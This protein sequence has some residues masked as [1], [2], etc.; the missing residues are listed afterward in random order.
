MRKFVVAI[1]GVFIFG[2]TSMAQRPDLPGH[3]IFDLG[4]NSWSKTPVGAD[5]NL[6]KSKDLNITYL[7]DLPLGDGGFTFTPGVGISLEKFAFDNNTT[8]TST[9]TNSGARTID[10]AQLETIYINAKSFERSKL[11]TNYIDVPL[12]FRWYARGT[13]YGQGFR[14]AIGGKVGMLYSSY[15]KVKMEDEARDPKMVKDRQ[16]YGV[17]Q[18]RYGILARIGW[19]GIGMF[20]YFELSNKFD[21]PPPGGENTKTISFGISLTGF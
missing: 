2:F 8:L 15:T 9:I 11:A 14:A 18:F 19:G 3:L 10:V 17:N 12:E 7:F 16:D 5:M 4:L 1:V 6:W 21:N 20:S 13:N